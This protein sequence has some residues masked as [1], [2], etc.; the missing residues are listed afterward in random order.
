MNTE[1]LYAGIEY[2]RDEDT[3]ATLREI[4]AGTRGA[5]LPADTGISL[6]PLSRSGVGARGAGRVRVRARQRPPRA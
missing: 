2:D 1:D 4:V 6:K 5:E 3:A